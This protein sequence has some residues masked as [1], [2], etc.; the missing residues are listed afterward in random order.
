MALLPPDNQHP[1][2]TNSDTQIPDTLTSASLLL[3]DPCQNDRNVVVATCII[4]EI[5]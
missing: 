5:N 1:G 4:G 3:T 2:H